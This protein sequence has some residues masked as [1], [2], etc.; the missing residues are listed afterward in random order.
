MAR[1]IA[2]GSGERIG[3]YPKVDDSQPIVGQMEGVAAASAC[4]RST[5]V[6][7]PRRPSSSRPNASRSRPK[8]SSGEASAAAAATISRLDGACPPPMARSLTTAGSFCM[9]RAEAGSRFARA[10]KFVDDALERHDLGHQFAGRVLVAGVLHAERGRRRPERRDFGHRRPAD[11]KA[12]QHRNREEER[13]RRERPAEVDG[14]A[15]ADT[16]GAVD[17][18]DGETPGP[19]AWHSVGNRWVP[20]DDRIAGR[21]HTSS[22]RR[23]RRI[24][25]FSTAAGPSEA[26]N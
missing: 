20:G 18:N 4:R 7:T 8:L 12:D 5:S 10:A 26:Q 15:P 6:R 23:E 14:G 13:Q 1:V 19:D 16:R 21:E 25:E 2:P 22:L 9:A 24:R 17:E 3:R 11:A